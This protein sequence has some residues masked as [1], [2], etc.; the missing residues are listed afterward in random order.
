MSGPAAA[1]HLFVT[2][3]AASLPPA[4]RLQLGQMQ[5]QGVLQPA[6]FVRRLNRFA[7]LVA[8]DGREEMAHVPNSGRL[9]ELFVPGYPVLARF[10]PRPLGKT[11]YDLLL[12]SVNGGW[13]SAGGCVS[14]GG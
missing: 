11:Q 6:T 9:Q 8:I 4:F 2:I 3:T 7:A 12:V 14:T 1:K 5:I 10:Q 13:V